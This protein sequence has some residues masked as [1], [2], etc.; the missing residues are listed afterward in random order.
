MLS[1]LPGQPGEGASVPVA[2]GSVRAYPELR[3]ELSR[4]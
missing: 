1:D 3:Q 2:G 4:S